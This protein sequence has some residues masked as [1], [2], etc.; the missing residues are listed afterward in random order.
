MQEAPVILCNDHKY[1]ITCAYGLI[2]LLHISLC[3]SYLV[4]FS[5]GFFSKPGNLIFSFLILV[6]KVLWTQCNFENLKKKFN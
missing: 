3:L 2:P 4:I 1:S 6:I 5:V